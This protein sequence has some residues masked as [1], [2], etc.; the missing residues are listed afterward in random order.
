M[1]RIDAN[2]PQ[3]E[4]NMIDMEMVVILNSGQIRFW[5]SCEVE[6]HSLCE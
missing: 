2:L 5:D 1:N 4:L 6:Q 3:L